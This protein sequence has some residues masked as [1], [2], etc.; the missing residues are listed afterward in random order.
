MSKVKAISEGMF[1][2]WLLWIDMCMILESRQPS[3]RVFR[4]SDED[5]W[6]ARETYLGNRC[7]AIPT[8]TRRKG[9]PAPR[10]RECA[11]LGTVIDVWPDNDFQS[12]I[13]VDVGDD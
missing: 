7:S 3:V 6:A 13:L 10:A 2:P 9:K 8:E 5:V 1:G 12:A 4:F 11:I